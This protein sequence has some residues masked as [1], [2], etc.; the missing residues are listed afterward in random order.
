MP[1]QSPLVLNNHKQSGSLSKEQI[2]ASSYRSLTT[3]I[4]NLNNRACR[5]GSDPIRRKAAG[6]SVSKADNSELV[7]S[8]G[9]RGGEKRSRANKFFSSEK[10]ARA[11]RN[12]PSH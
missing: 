9:R 7:G 1:S 2:N 11:A 8:L 3:S 6:Q 5:R 12:A 10:R 4:F